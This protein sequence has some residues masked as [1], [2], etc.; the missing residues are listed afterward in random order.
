MSLSDKIVATG[1]L[2]KSSDCDNTRSFFTEK[3]AKEHPKLIEDEWIK[4]EDVREFLKELERDIL[5]GKY[6][7]EKVTKEKF[8]IVDKIKELAGERLI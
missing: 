4:V 7:G 2:F 5:F 3:F 8:R 6:V 1:I